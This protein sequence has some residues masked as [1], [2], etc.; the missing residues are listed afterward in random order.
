MLTRANI[1]ETKVWLKAIYTPLVNWTI[2]ASILTLNICGAAA[3]AFTRGMNNEVD[4]I[5]NGVKRFTD[6][7]GQPIEP[8]SVQAFSVHGVDTRYEIHYLKEVDHTELTEPIFVPLPPN[9]ATSWSTICSDT[10][11][12]AYTCRRQPVPPRVETYT[13]QDSVQ[14]A[15]FVPLPPNVV[16][17]WS[18]I[19]F[20]TNMY[21]YTNRRRTEMPPRVDAECETPQ[22]ARC[23][24]SNRS[25]NE[26]VCETCLH[27]NIDEV[28]VTPKGPENTFSSDE[29]MSTECPVDA[30]KPTPIQRSLVQVLHEALYDWGLLYRYKP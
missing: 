19:C 21:A 22:S 25:V 2:C 13:M 12:Y 7:F 5:T 9:V 14:E 6:N 29:N 23:S 17:S 10:N 24:W 18:R 3:S 8:M 1:R 11:M 30:E 4:N 15:I 20:D 28:P 16:N 26:L 27:A